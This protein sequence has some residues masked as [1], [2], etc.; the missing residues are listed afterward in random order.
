MT[1]A[2]ALNNQRWDALYARISTFISFATHQSATHPN[3]AHAFALRQLAFAAQQLQSFA[4]SYITYFKSRPEPA[5]F[6][7]EYAIGL[8]L[9]QVGFDLEVL[10][11]AA[12]QRLP[13][14][15]ATSNSLETLAIADHMARL[16]IAEAKRVFPELNIPCATALVYFQ[17]SSRFH[18]MPYVPI[19]LTAIPY[20]A[21]TTK[22]DLLATPHEIAH[23]I[24]WRLNTDSA[25]E[26]SITISA[27]DGWVSRWMEEVFAD[28]F[29]YRVAG[30]LAALSLQD[31]LQRHS[32]ETFVTADYTDTHPA[33][34][35]RSYIAGLVF[36]QISPKISADINRR[37]ENQIT[38]RRIAP[39]NKVRTP[40][41]PARL[42]D[43]LVSTS[44]II[45]TSN[46]IDQMV[47]QLLNNEG[48][49][50]IQLDPT[51]AGDL[52]ALEQLSLDLDSVVENQ[53][54]V[55]FNDRVSEPHPFTVSDCDF[56]NLEDPWETWL[57]REKFNPKL[58]TDDGWLDIAHARGWVERPPDNWPKTG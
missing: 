8:A 37:W 6:T 1:N 56:E 58:S 40:F 46:P 43:T 4:N 51:W 10:E 47:E 39:T 34:M 44:G 16:V 22:R 55:I 23:Y 15:G 7:R 38:Q 48:F 30:P 57:E 53:L 5:G 29:S 17:K 11:Q 49:G 52:Q 28:V 18:G 26:R 20:T 33:P 32:Y 14:A 27:R 36:Q 9:N 35:L 45:N 13:T 21:I 2:L 19:A 25:L 54:D 42:I 41:G 31:L 12:W 24:F 3:P 50:Q